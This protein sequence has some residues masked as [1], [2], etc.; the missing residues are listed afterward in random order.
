MRELEESLEQLGDEIA[1]G[2][3]TRTKAR[4]L[5]PAFR[6]GGWQPSEP[7]G[8]DPVFCADLARCRRMQQGAQLSVLGVGRTSSATD[9]S[10][11]QL[12]EDG[13]ALL[14]EEVVCEPC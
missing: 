12:I 5:L 7:V 11:Q 8:D 6:S 13:E 1:E 4:Q 14:E 3:R 9:D 2:L 10:L